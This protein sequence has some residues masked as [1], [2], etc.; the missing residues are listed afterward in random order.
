MKIS[1]ITLSFNSEK[2]L[3]DTITSVLNQSYKNIEHIIIDGK[4]T[5]STIDIIYKN[6]K[7]FSNILIEEDNGIYDAMNKGL[8]L[9]TGDIIGFLNSDDC[10]YDAYSVNKI[11][12]SF[13]STDILFS[14]GNLAYVERN[15]L[16]S[17]IRFWKSN[18]ILPNDLLKAKIPAHPTFY[19]KKKIHKNLG[20]FNTNYKLAADYEYM[21]RCILLYPLNGAYIDS[22]LVK[23]RYGGATS[24]DFR[25]IIKQNIEILSIIK[26]SGLQYN[27]LKFFLYKIFDRLTQYINRNKLK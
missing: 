12:K 19:F 10:F 11:V 5:D 17:N 22:I 3:Q 4:S 26:S 9:A 15:N 14:Y 16:E 6:K 18:K 27:P 21:L 20:F 8:T 25:N 23:M 7:H 1:I 24:K 13:S 2:T